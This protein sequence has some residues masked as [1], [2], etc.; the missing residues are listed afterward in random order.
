MCAAG[1]GDIQYWTIKANSTYVQL[2]AM[3][4]SYVSQ[5]LKAG[6]NILM[7]DADTYD[8]RHWFSRC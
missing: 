1:V 2:M 6:Y 4:M 5:V 8:N 7:V 3:K